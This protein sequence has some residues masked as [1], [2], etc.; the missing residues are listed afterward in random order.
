[1]S[2]SRCVTPA[3]TISRLRTRTRS[4]CNQRFTEIEA[5]LGADRQIQSQI[6]S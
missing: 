5:D 2:R 1:M 3:Q 6:H 4:H